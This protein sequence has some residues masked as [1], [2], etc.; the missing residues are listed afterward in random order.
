MNTTK[1]IVASLILGLWVLVISP[2]WAEQNT[3]APAGDASDLQ[4]DLL[5]DQSLRRFATAFARVRDL[6][7]EYY[8]AIA[9][10]RTEAEA[11][12]LQDEVRDRME[13]AI[14][15]SGLTIEE[16]NYIAVQVSDDPE[17]YARIQDQ[18]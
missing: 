16:Y 4:S 7:S 12:S 6:S 9:S 17:L 8:E 18:M 2:A 11:I 13:A 10:A 3:E 15:S 14:E 5:N 1:L